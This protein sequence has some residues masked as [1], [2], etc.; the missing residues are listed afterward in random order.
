MVYTDISGME[1]VCMGRIEALFDGVDDALGVIAGS[2]FDCGL[3]DEE[4]FAI[5]DLLKPVMPSAPALDY[6][7]KLYQDSPELITGRRELAE[8]CIEMYETVSRIAIIRGFGHREDF[9][10]GAAQADARMALAITYLQRV[11]SLTQQKLCRHGV[12]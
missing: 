5:L 6:A 10:F 7:I 8:S 9:D 4:C 11:L 2:A 1:V 3:I 12:C